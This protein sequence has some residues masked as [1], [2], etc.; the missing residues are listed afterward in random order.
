MSLE[1]FLT[2][3]FVPR[4]HF[5]R[6]FERMNN[7]ALEIDSGDIVTFETSDEA[8]ERL[9]QGES[10]DSIPDE[11]FNVV[12][13]PVAVR[14]AERGDSLRIEI[15]A[16]QIHRAWSVWI[17]DYGPLGD[18]TDR[19]QVKP[20]SIVNDR[21]VLSDRLS[22]PLAPMIGCIGL[23]PSEGRASTLEPAYRFGGN[24]DL[25]EL[26][27]GAT[28][29]L[30]VQT[31]QAW[32]SIGDLHAG[33]GTGEPAHV[34]LEASGT[35]TLKVS[36]EKRSGLEMPRILLADR[37]LCLAVLDLEGTIENAAVFATQQAFQLLCDEFLLSPMEAYAYLSGC[38]ELRFGGPASPIV[39][40]DIP[41]PVIS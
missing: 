5:Q 37:T 23:A 16:I 32:L 19:V 10:P 17:P 30:P 15:L 20:L 11:D 24:L 36:V 41:H 3:N 8:Y 26:S 6:F 29:L 7:P 9:W 18:L 21:L 22:V 1:L 31:S 2:H 39:I 12:T 4:A 27:P 34:G 14:G 33:M 40:A 38:V 28:L 13:G 25:R 35:V